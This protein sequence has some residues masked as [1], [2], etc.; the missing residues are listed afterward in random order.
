MVASKCC[1]LG[2]SGVGKTT[3][4]KLLKQK[5]FSVERNPTIGV[6]IEKVIINDHQIAVWDLGGQKRFQF[7]WDEFLRGNK[8][9]I[10]VTDSSEK[11][12]RQTQEL[13]SKF[14]DREGAKM[15]AIANKQDLHDRMEPEEIQNR[16]GIPT[17]G[18]IAIDRKNEDA[19]KSILESRI[20]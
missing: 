9:A 18:M 2:E 1:I 16:L 3:L 8:L 17:Y 6:G 12:V 15:I 4:V 7:M 19:M 13:I 20:R 10:F 14:Q 5:E 11:N